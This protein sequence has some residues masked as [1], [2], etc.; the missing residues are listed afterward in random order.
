MWG[1]PFLP[2]FSTCH[3]FEGKE[4]GRF[5]I[6]GEV[7][8]P[9]TQS[10]PSLLTLTPPLIIFF[11]GPQE[12]K[13][14]TQKEGR[15]KPFFSIPTTN[16]NVLLEPIST[17][18]KSSDFTSF[19]L[20]K[21]G[22]SK[23]I[24]TF[25]TN[26]IVQMRNFMASLGHTG[27]TVFSKQVDSS[28]IPVESTHGLWD[29]IHPSEDELVQRQKEYDKGPTE[30]RTMTI[31]QTTDAPPS[32]AETMQQLPLEFYFPVDLNVSVENCQVTYPGQPIP[33]FDQNAIFSQ[34]YRRPWHDNF[35]PPHGPPI[36]SPISIGYGAEVGL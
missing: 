18:P 28:E 19:R 2:I 34:A 31:S 12:H 17:D 16:P 26:D 21:R 10:P 27:E 5:F 32:Y 9:P 14:I 6:V 20:L 23:T 29:V 11:I 25:R 3:Y 35:K 24:G 15:Q 13:I 22:T 36:F 7:V 33:M 1:I 8:C 4:D 30:E